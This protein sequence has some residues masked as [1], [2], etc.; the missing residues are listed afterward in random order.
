MSN[1]GY[2]NLLAHLHNPSTPLPLPTIQSALAHH[3]ATLS[4]LPTPLAASAVSAPLFAA[5]P[6]SHPRLQALS[7]AFRHAAHL[8]FR[9]AT[10]AEKTQTPL[11]AVFSRGRAARLRQ[12]ARAVL[13]G[14]KGGQPILRLACAGG[15]LAGLEDLKHAE[16]LDV[17]RAQLEDEIVIAVAES[18]DVYAASSAG[19]WEAEFQPKGEG[20]CAT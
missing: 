6:V 16:H 1:A 9:A 7:T 3:L 5:H 2:A 15:L 13:T 20:A 18:I 8:K 4:P 12:W 11:G 19:G 14:L 10:D 17:G